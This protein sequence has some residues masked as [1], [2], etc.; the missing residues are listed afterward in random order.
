MRKS[1]PIVCAA[2]LL[3]ATTRATR[4]EVDIQLPAAGRFILSPSQGGELLHQ[5]SRDAPKEADGY[6]QPSPEDIDEVESSL[7]KFIK[8]PENSSSTG[9]LEVAKQYSV[10][11]HRQYVG[12]IKNG[13]RYVYGNF[14]SER[15]VVGI[16]KTAPVDE[17]KP[18]V[19]CDGGPSFWGIVYR[20]STKRIESIAFNGEA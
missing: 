20:V 12:F 10:M 9:L 6:W 13:E 15:E 14:Y 11:F 7:Q 4:A 5:C 18:M 16:S 2:L 3:A 1:I 19:V 8:A 17:L